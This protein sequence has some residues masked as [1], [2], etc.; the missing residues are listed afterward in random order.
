MIEAQNI[1][2][3]FFAKH[4][5]FTPVAVWDY[6]QWSIGYGTFIGSDKNKRPTV[7]YTK[8]QAWKE[9]VRH[10]VSH[11]NELKKVVKV[12]LN[13][14]QWAA[15]LSFSYNLG[16]G[17]GR[18]MA[19]YINQKNPALIAQKWPLYVFAGG[20]KLDGLVKRRAEEYKLFT[21]PYNTKP[22][23]IL[24]VVTLIIILTSL[25]LFK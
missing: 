7:R 24:P 1:L 15:L 16:V 3:D 18:T 23:L 21:T 5:G 12:P 14:N 6:K 19:G 8:E 2:K 4:E 20:K 13:P 10:I 25:I 9:S 17:I 11:Y 22:R